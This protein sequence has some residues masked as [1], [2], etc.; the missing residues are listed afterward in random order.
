MKKLVGVLLVS[1]LILSVGAIA[2]A[3]SDGNLPDWF[4]G[5]LD[6]RKDRIEN[7]V[8]DGTI[9]QEEANEYLE[10]LEDMETYHTENGF[11]EENYGPGM[12]AGKGFGRSQGRGP[13]RGFG[14]G[15]GYWQSD[16]QQSPVQ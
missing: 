4:K 5:M 2:F 14:G 1:V 11:P 6:W 15:C 7:A 9:T 10:H 13:G 12:G 8:E 16:V 3:G